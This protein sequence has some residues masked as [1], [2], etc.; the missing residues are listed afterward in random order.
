MVHTDPANQKGQRVWC[1]GR[2]GKI[3]TARSSSEN[4]S[5]CK[6]QY[7]DGS[8]NTNNDGDGLRF[9]DAPGKSW[10]TI[11]CYAIDEE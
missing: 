1:E 6:I 5:R 10:D 11:P 4:G 2:M 3:T 9:A 8:K 7:D